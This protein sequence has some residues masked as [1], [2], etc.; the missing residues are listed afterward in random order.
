MAARPGA[1][2]L[3]SDLSTDAVR[4]VVKRSMARLEDDCSRTWPRCPR[5]SLLCDCQL[6]AVRAL[7]AVSLYLGRETT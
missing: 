4:A 2:I 5:D 6:R 3:L 1:L 7:N